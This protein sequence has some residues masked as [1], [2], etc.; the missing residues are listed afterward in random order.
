GLDAS[1]AEPKIFW[2]AR[3]VGKVRELNPDT[4]RGELLSDYFIPE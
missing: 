2:F 1:D 4:D 3:G